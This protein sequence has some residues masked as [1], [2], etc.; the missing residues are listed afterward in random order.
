M[1][2]TSS[3]LTNGMNSLSLRDMIRVL[4]LN[5]I[6][7]VSLPV[8]PSVSDEAHTDNILVCMHAID[9]EVLVIHSAFHSTL[10]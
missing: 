4:S 9:V 5:C 1:Q 6:V 10:G 2:F 7:D 3:P 8:K